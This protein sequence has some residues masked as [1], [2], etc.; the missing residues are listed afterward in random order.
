MTSKGKTETA[1]GSLRPD[2]VIDD[3]MK[4][5]DLGGIGTPLEGEPRNQA[6]SIR[7]E[8]ES[9]RIAR[10]GTS[11]ALTTI[12]SD[13]GIPAPGRRRVGSP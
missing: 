11:L 9:Y 8:G 5:K 6:P 4:M 1:Y 12:A 3:T 7:I 2:Y 13:D 10:I